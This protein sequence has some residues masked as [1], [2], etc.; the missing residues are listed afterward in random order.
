MN[1]EIFSDKI[2]DQ[3]WASAEMPEIAIDLPDSE[4]DQDS[5]SDQ[6]SNNDH[7]CRNCPEGMDW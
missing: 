3:L 4:E 5:N 7:V 6:D 1:T 2:A